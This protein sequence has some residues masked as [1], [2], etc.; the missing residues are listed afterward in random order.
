MSYT[1]HESQAKTVPPKMSFSKT[2][3][4]QNFWSS[5]QTGHACNF[6]AI[7]TFNRVP[8]EDGYR[9]NSIV[10]RGEES[11]PRYVVVEAAEI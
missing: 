2:V 10:E 7:N 9:L 8:L 5:R 1:V 3:S 4:I 11:K 6:D